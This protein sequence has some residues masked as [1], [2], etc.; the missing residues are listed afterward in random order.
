MC[1]CLGKCEKG[2]AAASIVKN[3]AQRKDPRARVVRMRS[4]TKCVLMAL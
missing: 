3:Y 4:G 2:M 1:V